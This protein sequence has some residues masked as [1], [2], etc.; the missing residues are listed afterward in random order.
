MIALLDIGIGNLSSVTSALARAGETVAVVADE[1]DWSRLM[2]EEPSIS[3]IILPGVGAFGDA[4]I[5][6]KTS[7]LLNVV[8]GAVTE[9][10][11]LL[12]IC[13]GMQLLFAYSEEH[14][15][16]VG[17]GILPGKVVRFTNQ[18]KVPHMGWNDLTVVL[19]HPLLE[20]IH[21]GDFV[22]FVHSFYVQL[23][24]NSPLLVAAAQYGDTLVPAVVVQNQ[25]YGTQFHPEKSGEVGARIL[26]NFVTISRQW[27]ASQGGVSHG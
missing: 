16:H 9:N 5:Q 7:G 4:M 17:L 10:R 8:R 11:P 14:G 2:V 22:Y 18:V 19:S 15:N 1:G 12:G 27:A 6:L 21:K 3:G 23:A 24:V 25:V 13:L 26:Q 20:G